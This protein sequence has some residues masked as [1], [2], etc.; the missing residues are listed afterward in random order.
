RLLMKAD[1]ARIPGLAT[2][3]SQYFE[4]PQLSYNT[5]YRILKGRDLTRRVV[6]KLHLEDSSEF[7]GTATPPRTPF[8]S[9][10]D[11]LRTT[12]QH[13]KPAPNVEQAKPP[14]ETSDESGLIAAFLSRVSVEPVRDSRLVDVTFRSLNP[15][16]AAE[17]TNVLMDEY[18]DQNLAAKLHTSQAT[19]DWLQAELGKQQQKVEESERALAE[20]RENRNAMSLD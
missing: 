12:I 5:Q 11:L 20:Y 7:N 1:G 17:A 18:V 8:T 16:F 13:F 6:K 14:T 4:D 19:L 9:I 15:Q 3:E 2:A 10:K